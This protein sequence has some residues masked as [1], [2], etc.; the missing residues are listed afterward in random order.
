MWPRER[1]G[2]AGERQE[3]RREAG[4][5][6]ARGHMRPGKVACGWEGGSCRGIQRPPSAPMMMKNRS[7][8]YWISG[9]V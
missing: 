8:W 6:A 3:R 9:Y 1:C 2:I 5:E 7:S 4:R